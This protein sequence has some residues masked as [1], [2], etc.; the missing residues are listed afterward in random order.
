MLNSVNLCG[1]LTAT[2]ELKK[3][4]SGVSVTS[5]RIAVDRDYQSNGEKQADFIDIVAWRGTAEFCCRN[6]AKGKMII[7]EG[8]LQTRSYQTQNG[9][10]RYVTEVVADAVHFAGDKKE[11]TS[12]GNYIPA[13]NNATQGNFKPDISVD[14]FEDVPADDLPF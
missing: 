4:S 11:N 14:D 3:T 2:P 5:F 8:K 10:N 6:F 12:Q 13:Q 9:D 1:R 7:V